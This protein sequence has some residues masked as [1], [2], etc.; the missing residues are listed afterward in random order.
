MRD[1]TAD[2]I[3]AVQSIRLSRWHTRYQ[4]MRVFHPWNSQQSLSRSA[5]KSISEYLL[6]LKLLV[7]KLL[8]HSSWL[9][10]FSSK[11]SISVYQAHLKQTRLKAKGI[12]ERSRLRIKRPLFALFC[13]VSGMNCCPQSLK[14]QLQEHQF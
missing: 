8:K 9:C 13:K 7:A 11:L 12:L 3:L 14:S 10:E 6:H 5:D 2:P 4:W 1:H